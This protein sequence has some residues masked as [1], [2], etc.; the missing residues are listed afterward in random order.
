[1]SNFKAFRIP[2]GTYCTMKCGTWHATPFPT[3]SDR[4][5]L[6]VILPPYTNLNDNITYQIELEEQM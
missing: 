3:D 1:M 2:K 4:I 5:M 6:F